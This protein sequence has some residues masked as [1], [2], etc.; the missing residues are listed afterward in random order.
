M[1]NIHGFIFLFAILY[2]CGCQNTPATQNN[3]LIIRLAEEPERLNPILSRSSAASQIENQLF[4]PLAEIDPVSLEFEP[5][6][7][8]EIPKLVP[9]NRPDLGVVDRLDLR[10][11]ED[12]EWAD[13]KPVTY[14]DVLFTLKTLFN[15]EVEAARFR[16]QLSFIKGENHDENDPKFLT[17][18]LDTAVIHADKKLINFHILPAHIYDS[19]GLIASI[20]LNQLIA[21]KIE[22]NDQQKLVDFAK[23]FSTDRYSRDVITGSGPYEI[24]NWNTGYEISIHKKSNW[25]GENYSKS[26][27]FKALPE[28][29]TYKI[30]PDEQLAV[31]ALA[32]DN[33]HVI[34]GLNPDKFNV[35][36]ETN[37]AKYQYL[38][39][40]IPQ[41]FYIILNNRSPLL[42]DVRVRQALAYLVDQPKMIDVVMAGHGSPLTAPLMP[43]GPYYNKSIK[44][45]EFN[46]ALAS[47]LLKQAGWTDS[48]DDG[49]LD[50]E[51]D[52]E[53]KRLSLRIYITGSD[54][55]RKIALLLQ[56]N[57]KKAGIEIV[58]KSQKWAVSKN[59][60]RTGNF[61]MAA[62][63]ARQSFWAAPLRPTWHSSGF[64]SSGDNFA[65]YA[66]DE[67]DSILD[68][69]EIEERPEQQIK[70]HHQFHQQI[71]M[72]VPV[73]FLLSPTELLLVS[74]DWQATIS[75]R[76]PGYFENLF[77]QKNE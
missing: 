16:S 14:E 1:K 6:L 18:Y 21:D 2:L 35:M 76:R 48:D 73:L 64:S 28:K 40:K 11:K 12:A 63:A 27:L 17:F 52:G 75:S 54:L 58:P 4:Q 10:L 67:M 72:D 55:G 51:I 42:S 19:V 8:T 49:Y 31:T 38:M 32:N 62:T 46:V 37:P 47:Q 61:E 57:M 26:N 20:T 33:V 71:H 60:M 23:S 3:E 50:Q 34:A 36:Q 5:V 30:I 41:Y 25:W 44:P 39:P 22:A 7:L 45:Y 56:D 66:S 9:V 70:L 77:Y 65:G 13:G 29:I 15:K 68:A 24:E 43:D 53:I 74:T 69:L 59:D